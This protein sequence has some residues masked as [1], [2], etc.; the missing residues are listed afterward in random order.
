MNKKFQK[1]N[2]VITISTVAILFV[3]EITLSADWSAFRRDSNRA[4]ADAEI[5]FY[6]PINLK[7]TAVLNNGYTYSSPIVY[8]ETV[9]IGSSEGKLFAFNRKTGVK[10]WEYTAKG[11]IHSTPAAGD[12]IVCFGCSDGYFYA[13]N[14]SDG[15]LKWKYYIGNSINSSP[16][17]SDTYV[18]FGANNG[19]LYSLDITTGADAENWP[20]SIGCH[21]WS[22]PAVSNGIIYIGGYNGNLYAFDISTGNQKWVYITVP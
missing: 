12:G 6:S 18:Y 16:I 8:G 7:W 2:W 10:G 17:I 5:S 21:L 1:S 3:P 4:G 11:T 19:Y 22:S 14:I 9:F 20:K 15:S 13:L